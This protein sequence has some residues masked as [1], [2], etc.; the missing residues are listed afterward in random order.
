MPFL[1]NEIDQV[2]VLEKVRCPVKQSTEKGLTKFIASIDT[3]VGLD[4]INSLHYSND[5]DVGWWY[6]R[7]QALRTTVN[8][9]FWFCALD[10]Y[11][12]HVNLHFSAIAS[13]HD[14]FVFFF[15]KL[16]SS[17]SH[18]LLMLGLATYSKYLACH[19]YCVTV[20]IRQSGRVDARGGFGFVFARRRLCRHGRMDV[21]ITLFRKWI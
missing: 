7:C 21:L 6:R 14:H 10:T 16:T 17:V 5:F 19:S 13:L 18:R 9:Q 4:F 8:M 2:Q 15:A 3:C 1:N 20:V 12:R 11:P